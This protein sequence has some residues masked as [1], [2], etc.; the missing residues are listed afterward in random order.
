VNVPVFKDSTGTVLS[1]PP[2]INS[3]AT[4]MEIGTKDVFVEVTALEENKANIVL[5]MIIANFSV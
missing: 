5:N 1:M 2:I 4:K 3:E